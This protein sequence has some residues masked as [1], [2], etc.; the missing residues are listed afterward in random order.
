MQEKVKRI[1]ESAKEKF[2]AVESEFDL[3]V[4]LEFVDKDSYTEWAQR[5]KVTQIII[6]NGH[7]N[8]AGELIEKLPFANFRGSNGTHVII[9]YIPA[10]ENAIR[11]ESEQ[12][13]QLFIDGAL[14]HE[15]KHATVGTVL[16]GEEEVLDFVERNFPLHDRVLQRLQEKLFKKP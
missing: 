15:L 4:V 13:A 7:A 1:F 16:S 2:I 6:E 8:N 12:D 11:G 5:Q 10:I 9:A 14:I 3:R